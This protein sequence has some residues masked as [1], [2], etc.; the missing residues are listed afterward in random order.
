MRTH[1]RWTA[2][3]GL[4]QITVTLQRPTS[5]GNGLRAVPLNAT[6]GVPYS[7][8][9]L[10]PGVR[11]QPD[12]D[13]TSTTLAFISTC[14]CASCPWRGLSH[15][16]PPIDHSLSIRLPLS[17]IFGR[18]YVSEEEQFANYSGRWSWR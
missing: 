15:V 18:F 10:E 5:V 3:L 1:V 13:G 7:A 12:E 2:G 14:I 11:L 16:N 17:G 9:P 6:E 8:H 4:L